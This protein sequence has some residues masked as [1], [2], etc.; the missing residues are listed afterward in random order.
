VVS[1]SGAGCSN[2]M[3]REIPTLTRL[4]RT[5][6]DAETWSHG[7]SAVSERGGGGWEC[8]ANGTNFAVRRPD[9]N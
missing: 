2:Y 9:D 1:R 5:E 3:S 6:I 4:L 7:R 8:R